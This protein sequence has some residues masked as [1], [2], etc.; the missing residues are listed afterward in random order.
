MIMS[1]S[2]YQYINNDSLPAD[3]MAMIWV[4]IT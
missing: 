1:R 3:Q 4:P 2:Q